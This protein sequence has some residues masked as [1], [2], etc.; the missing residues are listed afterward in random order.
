MMRLARDIFILVCVLL[1][2]ALPISAQVVGPDEFPVGGVLGWV[3]SVCLLGIGAVWGLHRRRQEFLMKVGAIHA[4]GQN[5]PAIATS[6][7]ITQLMNMATATTSRVDALADGAVEQ[8]RSIG[9]LK[10][11]IAELN[12]E[13]KLLRQTVDAKE[14]VILSKDIE[15]ERL[16]VLLA[17][18][19]GD[20][21]ANKDD[22]S[23]MGVAVDG[24]A[25]AAT[26]S[27]GSDTGTTTGGDSGDSG[28]DS[29][30]SDSH[31]VG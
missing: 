15:I 12:G 4:E 10:E 9:E 24:V 3:V 16:K 2:F 26:I 5:A 20:D 21:D 6:D 23:V 31:A 28:N 11:R 7:L 17:K 30:D 27:T 18:Y 19:E 1:L 29:G 22:K 25:G 8:E 14:D 13:I